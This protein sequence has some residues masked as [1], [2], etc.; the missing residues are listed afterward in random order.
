MLNK[1]A[2][3]GGGL[4]GS[5]VARVAKERGLSQTIVIADTS[6]EARTEIKTLGF[7]DRVVA[8]AGEAV[9][10]ADLVIIAVPVRAFTQVLQAIKDSL[11]SGAIVSDVGSVKGSV[12]SDM[13]AVLP[14]TVHIIPA[15]PIAGA[16]KSGPAAGS[17]GLFQDRWLIITPPAQTDKA[18]LETLHHFWQGC[19][20]M[21]EIMDVSHHDEVLGVTSHLPHLI[22]FSMMKT[23]AD[24]ESETQKE[25]IRYSA[26]GFRDFT[27]VAASDPTMWRDIM[28]ANKEVMLPLLQRFTEDLTILQKFIRRG[29]GDAL[30]DYFDKARTIRKGMK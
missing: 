2:I 10:E 12:L 25:I 14:D 16:E 11:K 30:H 4:I 23:A 17:A 24:L 22:A 27:R 6:G 8:D 15:H 13:Q 29:E 5:S 28:L 7:A 9:I 26:G 21:V 1:I 3:I 20:A 19:G 18:A